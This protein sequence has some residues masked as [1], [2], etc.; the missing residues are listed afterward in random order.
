MRASSKHEITKLA[1]VTGRGALTRFMQE[2]KPFASWHVFCSASIRRLFQG[3]KKGTGPLRT[4]DSPGFAAG[5][6][7]PVPFFSERSKGPLHDYV[8][9]VSNRRSIGRLETGPTS[10]QRALCNVYNQWA[11]NPFSISF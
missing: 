4:R 11:R 2:D 3:E 1:R 5:L 10:L 8:G 9:P 6:R 7:G